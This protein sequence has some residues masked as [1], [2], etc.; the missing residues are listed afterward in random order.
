LVVSGYAWFVAPTGRRDASGVFTGSQGSAANS[1]SYRRTIC[2]TGDGA[3]R[4][5]VITTNT[6]LVIVG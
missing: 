6:S 4:E 2:N 1:V 5:S 3:I